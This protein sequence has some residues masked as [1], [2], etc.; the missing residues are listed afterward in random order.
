MRRRPLIL[1]SF[2]AICAA[3]LLFSET[4]EASNVV[5]GEAESTKLA[6]RAAKA[7]TAV[8]GV[9][10]TL[11][12]AVRTSLVLQT[13]DRITD[14][15]P[16]T[17]IDIQTLS[18]VNTRSDI[19]RTKP[20]LLIA[21]SGV[22]L[23]LVQTFG[24]KHVATRKRAEAKD[25]SRSVAS[26]FVV[27]ADRN[28]IRTLADLRGKTVG[29]GF[30][31]SVDG[32]LAAQGEIQRQGYDPE[33]FFREERFLLYP[34]PDIIR[35]LMKGSIDAGI[36]PAC[37]IEEL[38]SKHALAPGLLRAVNEK[39]HDTLACRHSTALYPDWVVA[40][41][42]R[43][44]PEMVRDVTI[45]LLTMPQTNGFEWWATIDL[46]GLNDLYKE[47]RLGP[48]AFLRDFSPEGLITRFRTELTI[49]LF[50]LLAV[51]VNEW[52]LRL[53]VRR[54]TAE[55]SS[56]LR[57]R[58]M[59]AELV[60]RLQ[61]H[62]ARTER[63]NAVAQLSSMIAHELKQPIGSVMN[64]AAALSAR[65]ADLLDG[66]PECREAIKK[67]RTESKRI[68]EIVDSVRRYAKSRNAPLTPCSL[69]GVVEK[70]VLVWRSGEGGRIVP[71]VSADPG[72]TVLGNELELEL[73]VLNLIRNA[74]EAQQNVKTPEIII[75]IHAVPTP[76]LAVSDRGPKL[77]DA[78]LQRLETSPVSVKEEGLGLGL[79]LVRRIATMS[80][81]SLH[82]ERREGN[83]LTA[84]VIFPAPKSESDS[85][86]E[87]PHEQ[88]Q[89]A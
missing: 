26:V 38:E 77:S 67:I 10:E 78:E 57:E 68:S 45:A 21:P 41:F 22:Y 74:A 66:R 48:W 60:R 47:L 82:F 42:E 36:F 31:D 35:A 64:Y 29:A 15:L 63:L 24:L 14:A 70:A 17:A 61:A 56:A 28:D 53:L 39:S 81:A 75:E 49:A 84:R 32:W 86:K 2:S 19:E 16:D 85:N 20:D 3:A 72:V 79:E 83:G 1:L 80:D 73:L 27:L 13:I 62:L 30:P 18:A 87:S 40:S 43:A 58:D 76:N 51:L 88:S 71:V 89:H 54:R 37:L 12:P 7:K 5:S 25:P 4:P 50:L 46:R 8:I 65:M 9:L 6:S 69:N 33:N 44:S 23:D 55:L 59:N 52:R 11:D 34:F